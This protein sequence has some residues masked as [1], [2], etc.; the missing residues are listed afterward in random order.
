M[1]HHRRI[2]DPT[3]EEILAAEAET[4]EYIAGRIKQ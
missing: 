2:E 4:Y 1:E 3:V